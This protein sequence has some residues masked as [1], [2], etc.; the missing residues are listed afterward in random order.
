MSN[1]E[2]KPYTCLIEGNFGDHNVSEINKNMHVSVQFVRF[3]I[4]VTV[5]TAI[6]NQANALI[7]DYTSKDVS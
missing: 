7:H 2:N 5:Q 1:T 3:C 6:E 4:Q